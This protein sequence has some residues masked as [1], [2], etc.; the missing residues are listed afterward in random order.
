[1][2]ICHWSLVIG[3]WSLVIGHWSLVICHWS[4]VICH[5][6]LVIG[7]WSLVLCRG[8]FSDRFT[9]KIIHLWPKASRVRHISLTHLEIPTKPA[10]SLFQAGYFCDQNLSS[11]RFAYLAD[12]KLKIVDF[13]YSPAISI[14]CGSVYLPRPNLKLA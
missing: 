8:R 3:H 2:V 4:L 13:T 5:W 9:I 14:S 1:L 6:S 12:L 11:M 10:F 7:H